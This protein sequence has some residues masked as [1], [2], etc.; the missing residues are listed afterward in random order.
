MTYI[1]LDLETTGLDTVHD[2]ILEVGVAIVDDQLEIVDE[3]TYLF[4]MSNLVQ[5]KLDRADLIVQEMHTEN[6]LI[7]EMYKLQAEGNAMSYGFYRR[8]LEAVLLDWF[9]MCGL[10]PG[11]CVLAGSGVHFDRAFMKENM[12]RVEEFFHYRNWDVST[13]KRAV[14]AF[15]PAFW[16]SNAI[17]HAESNHRALDDVR[18]AIEHTR[19]VRELFILGEPD[20][21]AAE[22][23]L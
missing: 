2:L 19:L 6:H 8:A 16:F 5:D 15:A 4:P 18:L 7:A 12:P 10:E 1:F 9:V 13:L 3:R 17:F 23:P 20:T 11:T 14:Q 22:Q 21:L